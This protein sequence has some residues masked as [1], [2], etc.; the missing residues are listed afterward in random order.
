MSTF[1]WIK[2]LVVSGTQCTVKL[3]Q[4]VMEFIGQN[5]VWTYYEPPSKIEKKTQPNSLT[6]IFHSLFRRH[7]NSINWK[8]IYL[9]EWS[10]KSSL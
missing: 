4:R 8:E 9:Y 10:V 6:V 5:P 7:L 1:L 3:M 2:L